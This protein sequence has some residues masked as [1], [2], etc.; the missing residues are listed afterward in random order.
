MIQ[1]TVD[2]ARKIIAT[3]AATEAHHNYFE[4]GLIAVV[5]LLLVSNVLILSHRG[6]DWL[7][8]IPTTN[9]RLVNGIALFS[10]FNISMMLVGY[11]THTYPP[12]DFVL[13]VESAILI[14]CGLDVTQYGIKRKTTDADIP[15]IQNVAG[16]ITPGPATSPPAPPPAPIVP[17][18]VP[19]VPALPG[20]S[21]AVRDDSAVPDPGIM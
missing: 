5:I 1:T 2:T 20:G 10:G 21:A 9:L 15:S 6:W 11:A 4:W 17:A 14:M 19:V 13:A 8:T 18:N 12:V 16:G 7:S 3:A